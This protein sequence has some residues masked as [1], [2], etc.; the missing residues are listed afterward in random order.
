MGSTSAP[1]MEAPVEINHQ[2]YRGRPP[3]GTRSFVVTAFDTSARVAHW[4]MYNIPVT[5]TELPQN[6][7]VTGS[8]YGNKSSTPK[9]LPA[10]TPILTTVSHVLPLIISPISTITFSRFTLSTRTSPCPSR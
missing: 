5:T 3:H 10:T 2:S 1:L 8:S 4:G 6:A 7:G 9:V